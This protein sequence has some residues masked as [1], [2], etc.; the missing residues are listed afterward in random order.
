MK[1]ILFIA[2]ADIAKRNGVGLASLAY[3][4]A[5]CKLYPDSVDLMMPL[6]ACKGKY[7]EAIGVPQRSRYKAILSGSMHRYKDFLQDYLKKHHDEYSLCIINGGRYAGDMMDMIHHHGLKIMVIHH[8][9][10]REYCMDNKNVYTLW[11]LT[12]IFVNKIEKKAYKEAD[13]NCFLTP[14]DKELFLKYY[15]NIKKKSFVIG[16]FEPEEIKAET[17]GSENLKR[18][19]ITGSMNTYQTLCGIKDLN[20]RYYDKIRE[21]CPEWDVVIAGRNP[22]KDVYDLQKRNPESIKV[23]PNPVNMNDITQG[24]SIFLCPTNVGGG[25]K[26]RVMDGLRQ[27]L[28]V[29]VHKVSARGYNNFYEKPYF[30][31]YYNQETFQQGLVNLRKLTESGVDKKAIQDDYNALF[32][33]ERGC[34]LIKKALESVEC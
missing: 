26:L 8:N 2:I 22:G 4:N 32:G 24:V 27:G 25:L 12:P 23:I 29:L 28:P 10:E 1:R 20:N 34:D 18:I 15:G 3:Y 30:Q 6:E 33:F 21:L 17:V 16:V 5:V 31:I 14:E 9:F 19:A 7:S 11:G 13:V